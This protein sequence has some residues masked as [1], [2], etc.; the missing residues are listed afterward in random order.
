V[1]IGPVDLRLSMGL[2]GSDNNEEIFLQALQKVL[3]ICR[4]LGKPVGTFA[5]DSEG[6]QK[7]TA[8]GFDFLMV[9][10]EVASLVA[11]AKTILADCTKGI[12]AG[13]L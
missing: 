3:T 11:G 10:G 5:S 8:E 4:K 7:R 9:P 2:P 1:F 6:C 13:K 12:R